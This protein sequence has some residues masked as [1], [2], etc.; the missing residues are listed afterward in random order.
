MNHFRNRCNRNLVGNIFHLISPYPPLP[1]IS[2]PALQGIS[3]RTTENVTK[4]PKCLFPIWKRQIIPAPT[5]LIRRETIHVK[6]ILHLP[7]W[8]RGNKFQEFRYAQPHFNSKRPDTLITFPE[9]LSK[10]AHSSNQPAHPI[11]S[12]ENQFPLIW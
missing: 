5:Y 9:R 11:G 2:S 10:Q 3:P 1:D 8:D 4:N 7:S 6:A 12:R